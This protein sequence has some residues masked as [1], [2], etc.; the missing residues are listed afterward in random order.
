[1]LQLRETV[2]QQKETIGSQR[3]AIRELTG[4]L[5]RCEGADGKSAAGAWKNE[6]GKGKDTM[7]DLPRDPAQVIDQLSRTMQTLKD[8]LESLEV[9]PGGGA[10][11]RLAGTSGTGS[12]RNPCGDRSKL[13]Q[14][15]GRAARL[16]CHV[17]LVIYLLS[18]MVKTV[19]GC[20]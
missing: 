13:A 9:G 12:A 10:A 2:L 17:L 20:S 16:A 4:K 7:G 11:S 6:V 14:P 8:R 3:E 18:L 5:S 1:M 19:R 15:R